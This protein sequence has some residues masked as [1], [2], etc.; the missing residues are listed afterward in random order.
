[1][2][3]GPEVKIAADYF[4]N[5]FSNSKKLEFVII[6]D[7]YLEKYNDVFINF[8]KNIIIFF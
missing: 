7:Y 2:P 4:N 8:Y 6:T 5:F 3:E 1:M